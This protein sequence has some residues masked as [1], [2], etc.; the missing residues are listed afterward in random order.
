MV[1]ISEVE[2]LNKAETEEKNYNWE[3]AAKL[4]EQTAK[5]FL[6]KHLFEDAAKVYTKFGE[7]CLRVVRASQTKEDYLNWQYLRLFFHAGLK[8]ES[9]VNLR[10]VHEQSTSL[11][12]PCQQNTTWLRVFAKKYS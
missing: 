8:W 2:L 4:Y 11:M 6:D 9:L 10:C 7:I 5:L 12:I 3:E 1:R